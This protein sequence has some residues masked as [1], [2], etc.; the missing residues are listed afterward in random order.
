M[1][2]CPNFKCVCLLLSRS[3]ANYETSKNDATQWLAT[4]LRILDVA[5]RCPIIT[6]GLG[7]SCVPVL[8]DAS[9]GGGGN[10][11]AAGGWS[12]SALKRGGGL[13]S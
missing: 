11:D 1:D 2:S 12:R 4:I 10:G 7:M 13:R 6:S 3:L 9:S 5:G 8:I